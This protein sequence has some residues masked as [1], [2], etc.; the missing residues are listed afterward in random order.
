MEVVSRPHTSR[1]TRCGM[2]P[3]E[4]TVDAAAGRVR[5]GGGRLR[6]APEELPVSYGRLLLREAPRPSAGELWVPLGGGALLEVVLSDLL[7]LGNGRIEAETLVTA[8][9]EIAEGRFAVLTGAVSTLDE[10][11]DEAPVEAADGAGDGAAPRRAE[12]VGWL[13]AELL[14]R[15]AR[16]GFP[17]GRP[18][19]LRFEVDLVLRLV[20]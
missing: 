9:P 2:S 14:G 17:S 3:G 16:P 12:L 20:G 6:G 8:R 7:P 15:R 10:A 13:P 18:A 1:Q 19:R 4:W 11:P 5:V